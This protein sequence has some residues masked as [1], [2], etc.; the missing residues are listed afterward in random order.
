MNTPYTIP[1]SRQAGAIQT[2]LANV[3]LSELRARLAY[4]HVR[5]TCETLPVYETWVAA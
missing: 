5:L 4:D 1:T 2:I 3:F